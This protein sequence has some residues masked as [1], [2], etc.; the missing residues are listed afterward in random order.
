MIDSALVNRGALRPFCGLMAMAKRLHLALFA[1][2]ATLLAILHAARRPSRVARDPPGVGPAPAAGAGRAGRRAGHPARVPTRSPRCPGRR[3]SRSAET[4]S[5]PRITYRW[6]ARA[7]WWRTPRGRGHVPAVDRAPRRLPA[8][9]AGGGRSPGPRSP[10]EIRRT[11]STKPRL[12][13]TS[14]LPR[15]RD[16]W[17]RARRISTPE[18]TRHRCCCLPARASSTSR[19]RRRA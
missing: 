9:R 10:R 15:R 12:R 4:T 19:W 6:P 17:R 1:S 3:A 14:R 11:A 16:G 8:A 2:A 7:R 5:R 18:P 13:S